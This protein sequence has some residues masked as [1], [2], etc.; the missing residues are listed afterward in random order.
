MPAAET[1]APT[2]APIHIVGTDAIGAPQNHQEAP[3]ANPGL[4]L[5]EAAGFPLSPIYSPNV[6]LDGSMVVVLITTGDYCNSPAHIRAIEELRDK[7]CIV[8]PP[9]N[10]SLINLTKVRI[11]IPVGLFSPATIEALTARADAERFRMETAA[12]SRKTIAF[13]PGEIG[14]GC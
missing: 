13:D 10:H 5:L 6:R 14:V 2:E 7:G 11:D 1:P 3:Q 12:A 8:H 9:D 4:E